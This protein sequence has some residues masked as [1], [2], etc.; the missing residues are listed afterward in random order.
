MF[1]TLLESRRRRSVPT[2]HAALSFTLHA[3]ALIGAVALTRGVPA[4]PTPV[5]PR[6]R[7]IVFVLHS[8]PALL[9]GASA[10]R[11]GAGPTFA[12][13]VPQWEPTTAFPPLPDV[14]FGLDSGRLPASRPDLIALI[15]SD[16]GGSIGEQVALTG[17]DAPPELVLAV[18]PVYPRILVD[19]GVTGR[20][21]FEFVVDSSG[22][23]L[24][25]TLR[26]VS[27]DH[28]AFVGPAR[29]ALRL[30][31]FRAARAAGK[32][33]SAWARQSVRFSLEPAAR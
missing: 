11:R 14:L 2:R 8:S 32:P 22:Q 26:V 3:S 31:R 16:A 24:E 6:A 30:S 29:E 9:S 20:V 23:C 7:P 12:A 15:G 28:P 10:G 1:E 4:P 13:V 19:L 18:P 17:A 25:S 21:V 33:V 27:A 5:V